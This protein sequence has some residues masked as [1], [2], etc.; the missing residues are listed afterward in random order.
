V[1]GP[2]VAAELPPSMA[3]R[4][5]TS[6]AS[7]SCLR[8]GADRSRRV[9][10]PFGAK[11]SPLRMAAKVAADRVGARTAVMSEACLRRVEDAQACLSQSKTEVDVLVVGGSTPRRGLLAPASQTTARAARS[12]S[13]SP[14]GAPTGAASPSG[15]PARW[16]S[17]ALRRGP[18]RPPVAAIEACIR[19][20]PPDVVAA[21]GAA[22][23]A[24]S[25]PRRP[26]CR[27]LGGRE[28]AACKACAQLHPPAKPRLM[29]EAQ[30]D[31]VAS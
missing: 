8:R 14:P 30:D 29:D 22:V 20:P 9:R 15:S 12:P 25:Q 2:V 16:E 21:D 17:A 23:K 1:G 11:R 6:I 26:R 31:V 24:V 13:S 10:R 19:L 7:A 28:S 5:A 4:T 3:R 27:H 18:S